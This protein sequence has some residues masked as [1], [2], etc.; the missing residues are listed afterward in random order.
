[1]LADHDVE[2][3][4]FERQINDVCLAYVDSPGEADRTVEPARH[5]AVF[6]CQVNSADVSADL[7]GDQSRGTS[8][9]GSGVQDAILAFDP[10]EPD[11][12]ERRDPS[13]GVEVLQRHQIRGQERFRILSGATE[14]K[15]DVPA[16]QA[17]RVNLWLRL[18]A[19]HPAS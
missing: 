1:M 3:S 11:Q 12:P 6:G 8:D 5:L 10:G 2:A 19:G 4:G 9:P 18:P 13:E 14:G 7:A 15:L 17:G 16:C